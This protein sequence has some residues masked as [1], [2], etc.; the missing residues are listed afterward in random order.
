M[1]FP[2]SHLLHPSVIRG[3]YNFLLSTQPIRSKQK[4]SLGAGRKQFHSLLIEKSVHYKNTKKH[5]EFAL[6][7]V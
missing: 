4:S 2:P 7:S 1:D 3:S 5:I 6:A